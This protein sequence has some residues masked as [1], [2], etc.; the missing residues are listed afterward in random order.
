MKNASSSHIHG[1]TYIRK[2]FL[3][4][5]THIS[6]VTVNTLIVK[7]LQYLSYHKLCKHLNVLDYGL[8]YITPRKST[9]RSFESFRPTIQ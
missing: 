7:L 3:N 8:F 6:A 9:N 5:I 2:I 4:P 1:D